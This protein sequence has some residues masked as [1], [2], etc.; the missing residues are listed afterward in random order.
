MEKMSN[1][2]CK[3][4]VALQGNKD[5]FKYITLGKR[6]EEMGYD[7][8]YVYDDLPYYPSWPILSLIAEHT[9]NIEVGPCI[10][11]GLH[12]HPIRIARNAIFLNRLSRG[13]LVLGIGKGAFFDLIGIEYLKGEAKKA[14]IETIK[15]IRRILQDDS[16]NYS[17]KYF[18]KAKSL[19]VI[20]NNSINNF[21]IILGSFSEEMAY[22]GGQYCDE[23]QTGEN[24]DLTALK[25]LYTKLELGSKLSNRATPHFSI[26]GI[27]CISRNVNRAYDMVRPILAMYI[28]YMK[29][30]VSNCDFPLSKRE[31][32]KIIFYVK[33]D[34][35]KK[36]T[37]YISNEIVSY[38]ALVGCPED[39]IDKLKLLSNNIYI[40]GISFG[41]PYGTQGDIL[42]DIR[43]IKDEVISEL[44]LW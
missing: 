20:Q 35:V 23:F 39:V 30:I 41:P 8:I 34:D 36:A 40:Y 12:S 10:V 2:K 28:P 31:F 22:F 3:S 13:R 44:L 19:K 14:C 18:Y 27:T 24:W 29:S 38:C 17:G 37:S 6:I 26:G 5:P 9:K 4:Y 7:R 42:K 1:Y 43:F 15:Y 25:K 32:E 11:S 33:R 21:P 16:S